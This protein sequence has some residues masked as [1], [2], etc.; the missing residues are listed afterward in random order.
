[1]AARTVAQWEVSGSRVG[2]AEAGPG[3]RRP[4]GPSPAAA[5]TGAA[6]GTAGCTPEGVHLKTTQT[7]Y[8]TLNN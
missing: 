2:A 3:V 1:M 4:E 5:R 6:A 7:E 8:V